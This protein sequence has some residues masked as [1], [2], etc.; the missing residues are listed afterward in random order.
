MVE[1]RGNVSC[2]LE[3]LCLIGSDGHIVR[4]IE[5]DIACHQRRIRKQPRIDVLW[6]LC[7]LVLEL[8]HAREI[9]ERAEAG[10]HPP[11][12]RMRGDVAL[13]KDET[14]RR[15]EAAREQQ[16]KRLTGGPPPR[17]RIV[18]HRQRVEIGDK[19]IAVI[20]LLQAPPVLH[21]S[22]IVAKGECAGGLN[23]AQDNLAAGVDCVRVVHDVPSF[24]VEYFSLYTMRER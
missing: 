23:A 20:L 17:S 11:H 1:P 18:V 13:D 24:T 4:L 12:L 9:A 10:Q 14:L 22:E 21:R 5:Q 8:R 15:V 2:E 3:V 16:S 6:V 7:R 19:I